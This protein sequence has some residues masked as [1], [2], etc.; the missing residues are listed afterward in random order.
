MAL[1]KQVPTPWPTCA[2]RI[3]IFFFDRLSC[4]FT[5]FGHGSDLFSVG[6]M[7]HYYYYYYNLFDIVEHYL[8]SVRRIR[9]SQTRFL[10]VL[11]YWL[12]R[13]HLSPGRRF[14]VVACPFA[15][16]LWRSKGHPDSRYPSCESHFISA[17][18]FLSTHAHVRKNSDSIDTVSGATLCFRKFHSWYFYC[19]TTVVIIYSDAKQKKKLLSIKK[20]IIH[21]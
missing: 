4:L 17:P 8:G 6:H 15:T 5:V 13:K 21:E 7:F 20:N 3:G 16:V 2:I 9:G 14:T 12:T 10:H 18:R 19:N 1:C 11:W